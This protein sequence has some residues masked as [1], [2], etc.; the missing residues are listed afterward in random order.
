M[1][2]FQNMNQFAPTPGLGQ[3]MKGVQPA[4]FPLRI[5]PSSVATGL[6]VGTPL[7]LI[8]NTSSFEIIVDLAGP[9]DKV[10]A[11]IPG[12]TKK[13]TYA[14]GDVVDGFASGNTLLLEATAAINA[15]SY[16]AIGNTSAAGGG[17]GVT[18]TAVPGTQYGAYALNSVAAGATAILVRIENGLVPTVT[19]YSAG[20]VVLVAGTKVVAALTVTANSIIQLTLKTVGGTPGAAYVSAITPGTGFTVTSTSGTDTST[21][22]YTITN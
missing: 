12:N 10:F 17:P 16:L 13:N 22:N 15:G 5:N 14:A 20:T 21:Y 19:A 4:T 1:A 9:T 8:A 7:K 3:P 18:A 6:Q 2:L 11:V